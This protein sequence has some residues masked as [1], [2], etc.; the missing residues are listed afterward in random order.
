MAVMV[1]GLVG[2]EYRIGSALYRAGDDVNRVQ[3][4]IGEVRVGV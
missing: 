4:A 2:A 1:Q 3:G